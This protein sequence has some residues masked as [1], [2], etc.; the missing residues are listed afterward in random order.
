MREMSCAS[1]AMFISQKLREEA[2]NAVK[3][4][5]IQDMTFDEQ[6]KAMD[7]A[8]ALIDMVFA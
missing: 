3:A 1:K 8:I 6:I 2:V 7:A 4:A 5:I